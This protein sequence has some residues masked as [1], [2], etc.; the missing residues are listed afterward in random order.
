MR[1]RFNVTFLLYSL[2]NCSIM[3]LNN[4]IIEE[5]F[6]RLNKEVECPAGGT[7]HKPTFIASLL[8][9]V[10]VTFFRNLE[11]QI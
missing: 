11:I 3:F 5:E 2:V 7:E 10:N 6:K 9:S 8:H 4:D 1:A